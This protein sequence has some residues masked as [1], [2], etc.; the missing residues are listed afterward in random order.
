VINPADGRWLVRAADA[1]RLC[2]V[3]AE[4]E[5]PPGRLRLRVDPMRL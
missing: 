5:R 2:G 1:E 3:L 4:V